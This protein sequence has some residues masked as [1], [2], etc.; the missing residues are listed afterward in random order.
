MPRSYVR[1]TPVQREAAVIL[2]REWAAVKVAEVFGCTRL[3]I[4][5]TAVALGFVKREWRRLNAASGCAPAMAENAHLEATATPANDAAPF[6]QP[7]PARIVEI[8]LTHA[9]AALER[10]DA[11]EAVRQADAGSKVGEFAELVRIVREREGQAIPPNPR[12]LGEV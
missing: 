9:F 3:T 6:V 12:G 4:E 5:R 10:G 7:D 1:L 11:L 8:A 2:Y